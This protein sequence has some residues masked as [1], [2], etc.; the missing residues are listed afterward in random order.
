M[1][2][3]D[4]YQMKIETQFRTALESNGRADIC[5]EKIDEVYNELYQINEYQSNGGYC[6]NAQVSSSGKASIIELNWH[7][8]A[9]L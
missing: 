4:G 8:S 1:D 7:R 5:I 9:S 3:T 6:M 2:Y